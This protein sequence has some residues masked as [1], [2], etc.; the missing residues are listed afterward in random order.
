MVDNLIK[1]F[2][3]N[4]TEFETNGI[5]VLPDAETCEITEERNGEFELEMDYPINGR[6]YCRY[7]LF[8]QYWQYCSYE[9]PSCNSASYTIIFARYER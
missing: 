4:E 3:S 8:L 6:H 7:G 5:G 2:D 9:A 1:L